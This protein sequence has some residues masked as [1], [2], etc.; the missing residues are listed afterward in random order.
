MT[1][2]QIANLV[3]QYVFAMRGSFLRLCSKKEKQ[4]EKPQWEE[5][6]AL[7]NYESYTI[8]DEYLELGKLEYINYEMEFVFNY[9]NG[10]L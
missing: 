5:D 3:A 4:V 1:G 9:F 8:I 7:E 6:H 2:K 10:F